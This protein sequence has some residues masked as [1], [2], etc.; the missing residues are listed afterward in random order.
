MLRYRNMSGEAEKRTPRP[1]KHITEMSPN[2][3]HSWLSR[4]RQA[5]QEG[6]YGV[7]PTSL[8]RAVINWSPEDRPERKV[9][10]PRPHSTTDRFAYMRERMRR[11]RALAKQANTGNRL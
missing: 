9:P 3:R 4:L 1:N 6:S 8:A 11:I 7:D 10:R 2:E 5:V